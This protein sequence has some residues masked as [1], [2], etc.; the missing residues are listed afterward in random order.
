MGNGF[1][2]KRRRIGS[3]NKKRLEALIG[4]LK[5]IETVG[6]I[7]SDEVEAKKIAEEIVNALDKPQQV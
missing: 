7:A 3:P 4:K 2:E 5:P 1:N 6:I